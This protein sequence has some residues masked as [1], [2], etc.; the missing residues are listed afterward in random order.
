MELAVTGKEMPND[1]YE[2][3]ESEGR[4]N[5]ASKKTIKGA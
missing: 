1:Q 3:S 4:S 5:K 2:C